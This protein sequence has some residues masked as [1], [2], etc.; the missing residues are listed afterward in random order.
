MCISKTYPTMQYDF[1]TFAAE[2]LYPRHVL[3][4]SQFV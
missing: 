4:V 2:L 1:D 3:V